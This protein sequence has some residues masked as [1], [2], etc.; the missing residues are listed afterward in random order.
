VD[1]SGDLCGLIRCDRAVKPKIAQLLLWAMTGDAVI[2]QNGS[3]F[4]LK[5]L[6]GTLPKWL[7]LRNRRQHQNARSQC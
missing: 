7:W 5:M 4:C 6:V 2:E 3:D 1:R